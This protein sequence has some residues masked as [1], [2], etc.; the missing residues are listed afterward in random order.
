LSEG[1]AFDGEEFLGVDGLVD[2]QEVGSEMVDFLEVFEANDGEGGG[3]EAVFA[4]ILCGAGLTLRGAR[5]GGFGGVGAIGGELF[6]GDGMLGRSHTVA[7]PSV[8][9]AE[10]RGWAGRAAGSSDR[11]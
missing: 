5:P 4:G 10:R 8:D 2:G 1:E 6:P 9:I 11:R 7:L 3:S